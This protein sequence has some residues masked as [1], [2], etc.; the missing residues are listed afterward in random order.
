MLVYLYYRFY[1]M[2]HFMGIRLYR[3]WLAVISMS[4]CAG[5][6]FLCVDALAH[7]FLHTPEVLS[8]FQMLFIFIALLFIGGYFLLMRNEPHF[9]IMEKYRVETSKKETQGWYWLGV[10]VLFTAVLFFLTAQYLVKSA[11]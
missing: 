1:I 6:Q 4:I 8:S 10:Y 5:L 7:N 2:Y 3:R 9:K 11:G